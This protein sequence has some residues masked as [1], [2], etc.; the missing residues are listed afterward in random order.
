MVAQGFTVSAT[1][2]FAPPA[3]NLTAFVGTLL[4]G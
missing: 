4:G 3:V 1:Y 2:F